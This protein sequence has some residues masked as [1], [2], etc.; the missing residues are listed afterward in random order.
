[1]R[2]TNTRLTNAMR[3]LLLPF[4]TTGEVTFACLGLSLGL[5]LF[6]PLKVVYDP[7]ASVPQPQTAILNLHCD[8]GRDRYGRSHLLGSGFFVNS[9]GLF[10]TAYHLKFRAAQLVTK[11]GTCR[12]VI[13][14]PLRESSS[15]NPHTDYAQINSAA[16]FAVDLRRCVRAPD[17]DLMTCRLTSTRNLD[18]SVS[19]LMT[20]EDAPAATDDV[21][22]EAFSES[23]RV[24]ELV[25]TSVGEYSQEF[26][27]LIAVPAG[28]EYWPGPALILQKATVGLEGGP[29]YDATGR[30]VG[31][32]AEF[33]E[34]SAIV[35]PAAR[36]L[37]FLH[38]HHIGMEAR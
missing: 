3:N 2:V 15:R 32:I 7:H 12:T 19:K 34:G 35:I 24:P 29:V 28:Y 21:F 8:F 36:I 37:D 13:D 23:S 20:F 4:I 6:T 18:L 14:V 38:S 17:M 25:K 31:M 27:Y 10:I 9:E 30:I 22:Y 5:V 26:P 33:M 16:S 11:D 1:V